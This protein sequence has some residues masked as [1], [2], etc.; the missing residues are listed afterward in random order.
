MQMV[1]ITLTDVHCTTCAD[2]KQGI[3]KAERDDSETNKQ[4]LLLLYMK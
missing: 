1:E 4:N 3:A 2:V